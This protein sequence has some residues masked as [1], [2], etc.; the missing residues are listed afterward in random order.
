MP[1]SMAALADDLAAESG[2]LRTVLAGLDA[3]T[4]RQDT[5]AEGWTILDQLTHLA[6]FDD[7]ALRAA[8]DPDAFLAEKEAMADRGGLNPDA[9]AARFNDLDPVTVLTWFD[10][11][12]AR[13]RF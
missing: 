3:P 4:W 12:R 13:S 6:Y 2:E 11:A 9:I 7:V 10:D 5:P 8:V 1:V